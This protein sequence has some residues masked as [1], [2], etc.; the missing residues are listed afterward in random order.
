MKKE[1]LINF[2][3]IFMDAASAMIYGEERGA[4]C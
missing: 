1:Y 3:S 4:G 2:N